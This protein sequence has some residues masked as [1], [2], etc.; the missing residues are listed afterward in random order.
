LRAY[1]CL[2]CLILGLDGAVD[3]F[4][5]DFAHSRALKA[6]LDLASVKH[7]L[8]AQTFHRRKAAAQKRTVGLASP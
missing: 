7:V 8:P 3:V 4:L 6:S 1:G 5:R 2:W